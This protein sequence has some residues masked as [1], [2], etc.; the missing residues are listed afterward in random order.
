MLAVHCFSRKH[1]VQYTRYQTRPQ[2]GE[3]NVDDVVDELQKHIVEIHQS[4]KDNLIQSYLKYKRYY[5]KKATAT[6][7]TTV[8]SSTRMPT[9]SQC[10]LHSNTVFGLDHI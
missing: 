6:P 2:T 5:D 4:A 7:T 3:K 8:T 10:N 9:T 1:P